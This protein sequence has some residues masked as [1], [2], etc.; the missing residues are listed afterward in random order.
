MGSHEAARGDAEVRGSRRTCA[1]SRWG[2]AERHRFR[3]Q[4]SPRPQLRRADSQGRA[5]ES[6]ERPPGLRLSAPPREPSWPATTYGRLIDSRYPAR[7]DRSA[8]ASSLTSTNVAA[9]SALRFTSGTSK[10]STAPP[11]RVPKAA[12]RNDV[13]V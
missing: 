10:R 3:D 11:A 7:S 6:R 13:P 12:A 4:D 1:R 2:H 5:Q 8:F 9:Y